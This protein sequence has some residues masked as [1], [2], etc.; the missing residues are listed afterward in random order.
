MD[1]RQKL[2]NTP[3]RVTW[4]FLP[5][6]C[7]CFLKTRKKRFDLAVKRSLRRKLGL[8]V[9]KSD[10]RLEEDPFRLLGYGMNSYFNI[11]ENL[12]VLFCVITVVMIPSMM[13]FSSFSALESYS[14]Y[15]TAKYGLGNI[16]GAE[17]I[18]LQSQFMSSTTELSMKIECGEGTEIRLDTIS[19]NNDKLVFDYGI[20]QT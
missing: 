3:L 8:G 15:S 7:C 5:K 20:I 13:G 19:S 6:L 17:A 16:G 11:M 9:S 4:P 12:M 1:D 18:C 10:A 2:R 14:S